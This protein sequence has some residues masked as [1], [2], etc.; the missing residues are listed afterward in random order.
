MS[1]VSKIASALLFAIFALSAAWAQIET[2]TIIGVVQDGNGKFVPNAT[3]TLTQT[4]T[5]QLRQAQTDERGAFNA[6]FMP[7]GTYSVTVTAEGFQK[8]TLSG[9]TLQVDQ[10]ANLTIVLAVGSVSQSVEVTAAAPL[11]DTTTSSLGQVIDNHEV[12]SMPL[13]G[14]NAFALGLLVGNTAPVQG[15]GTNLPFVGGSGRFSSGDVSLNGIDD[16]TFATAGSIGRNGYAI[17]PS[18]DAVEEFKVMT[19]NFA[20]E[21]GHAAGTIVSATLKA[22]TNQF[23]GAVFEFLRNDD[24]DANNFFTN[25]AGLPRT[26]FHQNQFGATV[27]GPIL[28][29]RV[30]FFGDYQG[31]RE[32]T[33]SGSSIES[34]P[35]MAWRSGD[36]SSSSTVIY[37][38]TTRHIGPNGTVVATSFLA[39]TGANK[40]PANQI[41]PTATAILALIPDPNYGPA[42]ASANNYFYA[43]TQSSNTDQGDIRVDATITEKNHLFGTYSISNNFQP[44]VGS[45]PGWIGGGSAALNDN[46]QITVSDVHIFAPTLINELRAG[47][48]YNNG[49]QPGGGPEGGAFGTSIGLALLPASPLQFPAISFSYS[50]A[51]ANTTVEFTGIGPASLNLNTLQT[52]QL[53]D[54]MSWTHGRHSIKWGA[55]IRESLFDVLKGGPGSVYGAIFSSSSDAPGSGLPLADFLMGF[56]ANTN[57]IPMIAKGRQ[58]TAYFGGYIQD[59]WKQ[60]NKLTLNMGLRYELYTQPIDQNNVGSLFDITTGQFAIPGHTPYSRAM[61][62]GDHNDWGPRVGFAYQ[63]FPKWVVR[64]GYGVFYAMRDQNQQTTQFSGNTPNIPTIVVPTITAAQT[65]TPPYNMNTPINTVPATD[66]LAGFTAAS[67]YSGQIKTQSLQHALMPRLMQYNLDLQY[68]LNPTLLFE[69]S[70]S[71]ARGSNFASFFIDENQE[72][73]S[74][75]LNGTN[76]QANRPFPYMGSSV[77]AVLDTSTQ[78]YNAL[79]LK[80]QQQITHGLQFLANYTWQKNMETNGDGPDSFNQTA[81][82]VALYTYDLAREK[83]VA[84]LNISQI[85]SVSA[86]YSLPLGSGKQFLNVNGPLDYVLGGWVVNGI[87][88]LRTGFPSDINTNVVP[89]TFQTYNVASCVAGVPKKLPNA[90]VDG[91]FNPAAFTVPLTTPSTSGAQITE[92]GNCGHF[93]VTGPGSKNLDSSLF[94]NFYFSESHR[95]YLQFRAEA[96]NTT[97]TPTFALPGASNVTLTCEGAPGAVCNSKNPNFGKLVNGSATGR[98]LQFAAKL[99]F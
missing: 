72:P 95:T 11:V 56:P 36:F 66:S 3:V 9:I 80:A 84:P 58:R 31:T 30:F 48:L 12:L 60:S 57:G 18:V 29:N 38:P 53:A 69:A 93:P 99:Y 17:V 97:N 81:T 62:N 23:H 25:R 6:Q 15:I 98:Q 7:L 83:G 82:S 86:L 61:V 32:S 70:Y 68:Q 20:A 22:G 85:A 75:A 90:G 35:P 78:N 54:N 27:G 89:P 1:V 41:N 88:S 67:P 5:G 33:K 73:F 50:G 26:P 24:F 94:K 74:Y 91:Y 59:D 2:G 63:A 40:I 13:N 42:G 55:D 51:A 76:T 65:V 43:P 87:L 77:L 37:D 44:A 34:V 49:T 8:K 46:D 64:G 21:Y 14:R 10:T 92:F 16:N 52:R 28:H 4:A 96:F 79:N 47:Y 19:H 71:G 39:E 45:F